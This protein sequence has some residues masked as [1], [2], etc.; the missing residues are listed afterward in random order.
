M[1]SSRSAREGDTVRVL[2]KGASTRG[3][4]LKSAGTRIRVA[5]E[6]GGTSWVELETLLDEEGQDML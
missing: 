5:L 2:Y 1:M 4:V 6:G 3:T